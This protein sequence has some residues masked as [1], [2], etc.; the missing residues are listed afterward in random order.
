[1]PCGQGSLA[2]DSAVRGTRVVVSSSGLPDAPGW[3]RIPDWL[4]QDRTVWN[5]VFTWVLDPSVI[6]PVPPLR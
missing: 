6:A 2:S 3:Q 4:P 1:M 5:S